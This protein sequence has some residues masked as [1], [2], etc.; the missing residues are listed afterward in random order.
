MCLGSARCG[1]IL[2]RI[3]EGGEKVKLERGPLGTY[4]VPTHMFMSGV[5]Y[6]EIVVTG[7]VVRALV[8]SGASTSCCTR[9]CYQRYQQEVGLLQRGA[10]KIVGVGN[11]PINV[12]GGI[13]RLLL[14]WNDAKSFLTLLVIPTLE[15]PDM[16]LG[17]D[18]LQRLG[19]M[20]STKTGTAQP[21]MLITKLKP[22]ESWKVPARTSVVF[23]IKN[24]Y[25]EQDREKKNLVRAKQ[26]TTTDD[27][28]NNI[29]GARATVVC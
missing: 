8:D 26:E 4:V 5:I 28:G 21:T 18:V 25:D 23:S 11:I 14:E 10:T 7:V 1:V 12:D 24:P 19:V 17:M 6:E 20:I 3:A 15:E 2:R 22:E 29:I 9:K 27:K 13:G 16:I